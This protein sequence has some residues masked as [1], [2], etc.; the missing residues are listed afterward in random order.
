MKS[1]Q[2]ARR[3]ALQG[4]VAPRAFQNPATTQLLKRCFSATP[5]AASQLAGLD[6]AKLTVSKTNTPKEL[7]APQDLV[8]GKTFTGMSVCRFLGAV[9]LL[10]RIVP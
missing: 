9:Q 5:V 8:F 7:T 3:R 10:M 1:L 4:L 2:F 6:P